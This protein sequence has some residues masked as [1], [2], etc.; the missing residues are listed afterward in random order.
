M[1]KNVEHL[2]HYLNIYRDAFA[3]LTSAKKTFNAIPSITNLER[4]SNKKIA[5]KKL[6]E[7][8]NNIL[9]LKSKLSK[10]INLLLYDHN[11]ASGK[12]SKMTAD[13][14]YAIVSAYEN[15]EFKDN[16]FPANRLKT[17]AQNN[18]N[19]RRFEFE[20]EVVNQII[21]GKFNF[22][23]KKKPEDYWVKQAA[24]LEKKITACKDRK[25]SLDETF[26]SMQYAKLI[27]RFD[28]LSHK[29]NKNFVPAVHSEYVIDFENL[30]KYY[31]NKW[32]ATKVLKGFDLKIKQ[33][34]F[35]VILG[36]SGSGKTT[37][38]NIMSGMDKATYGK[39]I[40]N[41][42]NLI[43]MTDNQL[44]QFRKDNI[45]YIFQQYGLLPNLNV[46]ENVEIGWNLQSDKSKR[47]N[48]DDLLKTVGMSEH[49]KKF[50]YELSGGQQQ[51]VSVARSMAKN[52]AI[53]FGDEP[54]GAVDEE[55]SKQILQLFVD[56]N[57][58]YNTTVIIV[59]HNPIFADLAS[60]VIKVNSGYIA[61]NYENKK[62]KSVEELDWSST[63]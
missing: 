14:L 54:T 6:A 22:S 40:V 11:C 20:L 31:Y 43:K 4:Y 19:L 36:P 3:Q 59:T 58:N 55:M 46:R 53:V 49:A 32:M 2:S 27:K 29:T 35:V 45:G 26:R 39:T 16:Y 12:R 13:E 63:H 8:E 21:K 47:L 1:M 15:K 61:Q 17:L 28:Q 52:P 33:G 62:R 57:K 34:E 25:S 44:T 9:I 60:R 51:R 18:S 48:I 42:N 37:L 24:I 23:D 30:T 41:S 38:L 50:P 56:I 10:Y 7:A 5:S